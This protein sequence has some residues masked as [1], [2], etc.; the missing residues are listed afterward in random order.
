MA[1]PRFSARSS[2]YTF[3]RGSRINQIIRTTMSEEVQTKLSLPGSGYEVISKILH[4]YALCGDKPASL[5]DVGG[6]AAMDKTIVSRNNGFLSSLGLIGGGKSKT[7]TPAGKTLAIALGHGL[8]EDASIAWQRAILA[9][10]AAKPVLD[11]IRIQRSIAVAALPAKIASALGVPDSP[12]TKTGTNTLIE[13]FR[14]AGVINEVDGKISLMRLPTSEH[15]PDETPAP[16]AHNSQPISSAPPVVAEV[17]PRL[18]P[19]MV[20][21]ERTNAGTLGGAGIPIHVNIELHLPAS[22][23][24]GVYDA[25]F[26][27]I[28]EHLLNR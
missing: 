24:Q 17:S 11:L 9:S 16:F 26:K 2:I 23:E 15:I 13:V 8:E 25:L 14:R 3:P 19:A 20:A 27:S 1:A 7:L 10:A 18:Q 6:R 12:A 28:R 21:T 22:A 5:D 4:A